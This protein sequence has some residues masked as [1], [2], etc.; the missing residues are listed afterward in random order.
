MTSWRIRSAVPP[1]LPA[2]SVIFRAAALSNDGDRQ[3]LLA[4]PEVLVF[5]AGGVTDGRTRV[6]TGPDGVIVGFVTEAIASSVDVVSASTNAVAVLEIE[7]L[8]VDPDCQRQGVGRELIDDLVA[9]ARARGVQRLEVVANEHALAFYQQA[10]FIQ[11]GESR[12]Q[13]RYA[14]HMYR[15]LGGA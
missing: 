5:G 14:P 13:F 2:L 7:D 1:D 4:H 9:S 11:D 8:F 6:A 12:T 10:G 3:E 15:D